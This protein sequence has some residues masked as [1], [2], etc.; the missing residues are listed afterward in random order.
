MTTECVGSRDGDTVTLDFDGSVGSSVQLLRDGSWLRT[1]TDQTSTTDQSPA[2]TMYVL[3][4]R[5]AGEVVDVTCDVNEDEGTQPP[6][7]DGPVCVVIEGNPN[8]VELSGDLG[9]STQLRRNGVWVETV[10]GQASVEL[11]QSGVDGWEI[12][13]LLYTSPSPRDRTRSRMP[14][15]A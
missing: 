13:C 10:T 4:L 12:R 8:R 9:T 14:S 3:R 5:Q 6:I 11:S 2:G 7:D 15:S 1:V